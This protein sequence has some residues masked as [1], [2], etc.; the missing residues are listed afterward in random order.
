MHLQVSSTFSDAHV[1]FLANQSLQ[2]HRLT[3]KNTYA[4]FNDRPGGDGCRIGCDRRLL[5]V[6][7]GAESEA[8]EPVQQELFTRRIPPTPAPS[9]SPTTV[10]GYTHTSCSMATQGGSGAGEPKQA[11]TRDHWHAHTHI[12]Q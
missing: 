8:S 11:S 7:S 2:S 1:F 10:P 12:S 4:D 5:R 6:I 9:T 3:S